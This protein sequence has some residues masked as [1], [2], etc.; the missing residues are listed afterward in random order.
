[1][2]SLINYWPIENNTND[3]IGTAHMY[4]GINATLAKDRFNNSNSALDLAYGYLQVPPGVY[5]YSNFTISFWIYPR[6]F[7]PYAR[8]FDFANGAP[9]NNVLLCYS[10]NTFGKPRFDVFQS[11]QRFFF[12]EPSVTLVIKNWY[13]IAV[14]YNGT[15]SIYIN[16]IFQN[17]ILSQLPPLNVIRTQNY[18]GKSNWAGN[19]LANAILDEIK[20]YNRSLENDEIIDLMLL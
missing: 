4:G 10:G 1:M 12:L 17:Q 8:V 11:Y 16:G 6:T 7:D 14:T 9:D 19:P 5:F 18:F 13:H 2:D 3:L 20:I 15:Y